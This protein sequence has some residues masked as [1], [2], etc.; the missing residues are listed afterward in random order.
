MSKD[1]VTIPAPAP[2][3]SQS[4]LVCRVAEDRSYHFSYSGHA[5]PADCVSVELKRQLDVAVAKQSLHGFWIGSD[6]NQE[7]CQTVTECVETEPSLVVID[8]MSSDVLV[9]LILCSLPVLKQSEGSLGSLIS[10]ATRSGAAPG[11][12]GAVRPDVLRFVECGFYA[13]PPLRCSA[14]TKF[15]CPRS[16]VRSARGACLPSPQFSA[17]IYP[18]H[19]F[20]CP[21]SVVESHA[22]SLR[23]RTVRPYPRPS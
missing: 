22:R 20:A 17:I 23:P 2:V 15:H 3:R 19:Q 5:I 11:S 8:Q 9:R 10:V 16:R 18:H 6:A 1:I 21:G 13:A 4:A 14:G 7:R 12:L